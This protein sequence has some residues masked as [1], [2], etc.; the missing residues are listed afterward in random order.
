MIAKVTCAFKISPGGISATDDFSKSA[1]LSDS[2]IVEDAFFQTNNGLIRCG[3]ESNK[4][5]KAWKPFEARSPRRAG[6]DSFLRRAGA[7]SKPNL[8]RSRPSPAWFAT[9]AKRPRVD[10]DN[11]SAALISGNHLVS[12]DHN[13]HNPSVNSV[14]ILAQDLPATA[15]TPPITEFTDGSII[16]VRLKHSNLLL[17][18]GFEGHFPAV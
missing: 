9:L 18:S 15:P 6:A 13:D 7:D 1:A 3:K 4:L 17:A 16:R 2:N 10:T 12:I 5:R 11:F 8:K 14:A